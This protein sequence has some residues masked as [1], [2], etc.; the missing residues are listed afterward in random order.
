MADASFNSLSN[1][2]KV[3]FNIDDL[4]NRHQ[5]ALLRLL[6][7]K[8]GLEEVLLTA[9]QDIIKQMDDKIVAHANKR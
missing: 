3:E 5:A 7:G 6:M 4:S 8:M 1:T 2:F 9:P